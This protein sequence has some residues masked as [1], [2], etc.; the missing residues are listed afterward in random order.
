MTV[1]FSGASESHLRVI[2]LLVAFP[3][4]MVNLDQTIVLVAV[5]QMAAQ[6][7]TTPGALSV[8]VTA[9]LLA[10]VASMP[11]SGWLTARC[12]SRAVFLGAVAVFS[13]G[14][15]ACGLSRELPMLCA[16]RVLQGFGGGLLT[17]VAR[18][19]LQEHIPKHRMV[20]AMAWYTTPAL[21]GPMLGPVLGGWILAQASW[22]WIFF[23]NLPIGAA[24][25]AACLLVLRGPLPVP[26]KRAFDLQGYALIV[27]GLAL[28]F[29]SF[30][31][32]ESGRL[33]DLHLLVLLAGGVI[34]LGAYA[35]TAPHRP[36]PLID[37]AVLRND[38]FRAMVIG[39]TWFRL[40][41]AALPFLVS[42]LLQTERGLSAAVTG[43]VLSCTA[44]GALCAKPLVRR[45]LTRIGYRRLL[46]GG[47]CLAALMMGLIAVAGQNGWLAPLAV[48]LFVSGFFRSVQFTAMNSLTYTSVAP[49]L[50][51][52]A[53]TLA[54]I[55]QQVSIGFG[56]V[57]AG[58][59][60]GT[61]SSLAVA[62]P[63]V[64]A[65]VLIA[66]LS[67]MSLLWFLPLPPQ[68]GDDLVSR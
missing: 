25:L 48:C 21:L 60:L 3:L 68:T 4:F 38:L 51:G 46:I 58:G 36:A 39:G 8:L 14:S 28:L 53:T 59:L 41:T 2:P 63:A 29:L 31:R 66:G 47:A 54:S 7:G 64:P 30:S 32:L 44:F 16:A 45:L 56:V 49:A 50:T 15:L 62:A 61:L 13:V 11:L 67:L 23:V 52:S 37:L 20:Q 40:P 27:A 34:A 1:P 35:V 33:L 42:I 26:D 10:L 55:L 17:P 9:Y 22:H 19:I 5:P 18:I 12:G 6:F 43:T 65:L 57:L 24:A